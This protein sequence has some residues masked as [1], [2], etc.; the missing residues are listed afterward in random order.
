MTV[1]ASK[2]VRI[3]GPERV[4]L[5][6]ALLAEYDKGA[7]IRQLAARHGRSIGSVRRLLIDA[8][9]TFRSRGGATRARV[10]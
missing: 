6:R 7:S 4:K 10:R 3:T 8:G 1:T 9:V 5:G 2:Y